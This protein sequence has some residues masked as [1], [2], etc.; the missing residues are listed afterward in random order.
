MTLKIPY[1]LLAMPHGISTVDG[2]DTLMPHDYGKLLN[3]RAFG[4]SDE[5]PSLIENNLILSMLNAK[6]L[7]VDPSYGNLEDIR[8]LVKYSHSGE[9]TFAAPISNK[10]PFSG[11]YAPIYKKIFEKDDIFA[12][13]N[14]NVLPRVYGVTKLKATDTI[15]DLRVNLYAFQKDP[16]REAAVS[17]KD[18]KEIG[19]TDFSDGKVKILKY[20]PN[21]VSIEADFNGAGFLVLS[22]QFYPGWKAY[23]DGKQTKIY[24][25][26]GV[27]RGIV[28][29]PG[30]HEVIFR[31]SPGKIY[32][33]MA[34]SGTL[35]AGLLVLWLFS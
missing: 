17:S 12:Y 15:N 31:Y 29:P 25:T 5:W 11:D 34:F 27:L 19:K 26:N 4:Y 6:Y 20:S 21:I 8:G 33:A 7:I 18:L 35:L 22:D 14:L 28:V 9:M 30:G 13:E 16:H 3:M 24:K 32:A 23:I 10:V 2:Y 1:S